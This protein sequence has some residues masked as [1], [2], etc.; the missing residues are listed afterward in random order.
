MPTWLPPVL[1][2]AGVALGVI[3]SM[4]GSRI[5]ASKHKA[6][7]QLALVDQ[8]QEERDRLDEKIDKMN[9]RITAFYADK[10]ASRRYIASLEN[11][12]DNGNPPPPP[13]PPAGYVP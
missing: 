6:E 2:F 8:L 1:G 13:A 10:H 9:V 11:H 3:A 7:L 4:I 12:I 5:T